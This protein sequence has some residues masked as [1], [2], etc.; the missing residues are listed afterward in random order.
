MALK[1]TLL[2][3]SLTSHALD[4]DELVQLVNQSVTN[5][6][7]SSSLPTAGVEYLGQ[8]YIIKGVHYVCELVETVPTWVTYNSDGTQLSYADMS[9]KPTLDGIT[10]NGVLTKSSLGIAPNSSER[11]ETTLTPSGKYLLLD[12][13]E[14]IDFDDIDSILYANY[15]IST[16]PKYETYNNPLLTSDGTNVKWEI[17]HTCKSSQPIVQLYDSN[18]IMKTK[19]DI[20]T[21]AI[22]HGASKTLSIAW[23]S[24]SNVAANTYYVVLIG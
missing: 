5:L 13:D 7:D 11:T 3:K 14:K 8:S 9:D 2:T 17:T 16:L 6:D 19:S 4:E 15:G 1:E 21:L 23:D 10:I 20:A 22:Q 24:A 12:D 18:G